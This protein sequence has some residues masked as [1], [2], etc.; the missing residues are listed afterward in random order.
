MELLSTGDHALVSAV[1]SLLEAQDIPVET[2]NEVSSRM[3]IGGQTSIRVPEESIREARNLLNQAD[4]GGVTDGGDEP[5]EPSGQPNQ[6]EQ[7]EADF[8]DGGW[9]V[10]TIVAILLVLGY[11]L[12]RYGW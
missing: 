2:G 7:Y 5:P 9:P 8:S 10:R 12:I 3:N 11:L 1:V 6:Y 4:L